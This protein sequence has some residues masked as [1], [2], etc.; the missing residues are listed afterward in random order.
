MLAHIIIQIYWII[1][2][3]NNIDIIYF[4]TKNNICDDYLTNK[5]FGGIYTEENVFFKKDDLLKYLLKKF[6]NLKYK[7]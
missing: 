4:T 2:V 6:Y 3:K 1:N 7:D 5:K